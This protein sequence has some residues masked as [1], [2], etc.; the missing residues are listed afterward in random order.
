ML[1][2]VKVRI[3]RTQDLNS[4]HLGLKPVLQYAILLPKGGRICEQ[5]WTSHKIKFIRIYRSYK[6]DSFSERNIVD[7]YL[8]YYTY[9]T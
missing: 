5:Q 6:Y 1:Y 7:L 3:Q 2:E 4:S 8:N 9:M